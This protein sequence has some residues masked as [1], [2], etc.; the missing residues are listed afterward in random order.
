MVFVLISASVYAYG[1]HEQESYTNLDTQIELL[2]ILFESSLEN[3]QRIEAHGIIAN[4]D[5]T[6]SIPNIVLIAAPQTEDSTFLIAIDE[7]PTQETIDFILNFTGIPAEK[8]E[9][10]H[11]QSESLEICY[12]IIA[13]DDIYNGFHRSFFENSSEEDI[14]GILEMLSEPNYFEPHQITGGIVMMGQLAAVQNL[15]GGTSLTIGHPNNISGSSFFTATHGAAPNGARVVSYVR[16]TGATTHQIGTIRRTNNRGN[17]DFTEVAVGGTVSQA[18]ARVPWGNHNITNFRGTPSY[19]QPARSIRGRS[20][21]T[22][23]LVNRPNVRVIHGG[24]DFNNMIL[25]YPNGN[26]QVG[27]SGTALIATNGSQ[28][29]VLGTR[30]GVIGLDGRNFGI[31]SSVLNYN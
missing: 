3:S 18:S 11:L 27:D 20:G 1:G 21:V 5:S 19:N 13:E 8:A 7:K 17:S 28:E 6:N 24:V 10:V 25:T 12:E 31:Y 23:S 22:L 14:S 9:I 2:N 30:R 15:G 4:D 16:P 26:S 29:I